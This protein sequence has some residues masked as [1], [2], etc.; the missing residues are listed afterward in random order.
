MTQV[1]LESLTPDERDMLFFIVNVLAP[2]TAPK[3]EYDLNTIKWLRHEMLA[4]KILDSF[5][6]VTKEAHPIY[7][8]LL[9]KLGVFIQIQYEAPPTQSLCP[10]ETNNN[11]TSGSGTFPDNL[12]P[13]P[14]MDFM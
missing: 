4:R 1:Q 7:S 9:A 5:N 12:S 2:T 13:T 6:Q 8:S 10:T 11:T 14:V 3:I